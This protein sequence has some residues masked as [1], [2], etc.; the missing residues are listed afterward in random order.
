MHRLLRRTAIWFASSFALFLSAPLLSAA[1]IEWR[2]SFWNPQPMDDDFILP[3]P[4]GG[5]MAFRRVDTTLPGNWLT[6]FR[7]PLGSTNSDFPFSESLRFQFVAGSLAENNDPATRHFYISKYEVTDDQYAAVMNDDCPSVGMAGRLPKVGL[8]WYDAVDFTKHLTTWL[9]THESEALPEQ[10]GQRS[11]IRLPTETE[12]EFAARGGREVG[13]DEFRRTVFPMEGDELARY[14]WFQGTQS[15]SGELQ[16]VGILEPNPLGLYDILGNA[17][18]IVLEPYRANL[19]G[20]LHGQTGGFVVKGG[21]CQTDQ[22][23]IS[24]AART[25]F[26]YFN[27]RTGEPLAPE[28]AGLR[29]IISGPVLVSHDRVAAF[30]EGWESVS[31]VPDDL[32]VPEILERIVADEVS[33]PIVAEHLE[34]V[35]ALARIEESER[36]EIER[37]A[38]QTSIESGAFI[39]QIYA[40]DWHKL[41]GWKQTL[42]IVGDPGDSVEDQATVQSLQ[43]AI[44]Q[45]ELRL[46]LTR[47]VYATVL[48]QTA[49]DY[50]SEL[51]SDQLA[52]VVDRFV[53]MSDGELDA[54][55]G[56]VANYA[57]VFAG[58]V[59]R[60]QE[61]G[62]LDMDVLVEE[63]NE[64]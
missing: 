31:D 43:M 39:I 3:L 5:A 35:A 22:H 8:S 38:I 17:E 26:S 24:S 32:S 41:N 46:R 21:S 55:A 40:V 56:L 12:W 20:R 10:D 2:D 25:E 53:R 16:L 29:V 59:R 11:F 19:S 18:E 33:S 58:H 36:D 51:L 34:Q 27:D 1:E 60:W 52:I 14:V 61:A 37:R 9:N 45:A 15:C 6:D 50:S 57:E 7:V 54:Q 62:G 64:L 30:G 42:E 44:D 23:A 28:L 63:L 13:D 47:N 49:D 4:C 48:S